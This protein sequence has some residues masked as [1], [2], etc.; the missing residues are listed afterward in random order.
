MESYKEQRIVKKLTNLVVSLSETPL[1]ERRYFI[2]LD[3]ALK[4]GRKLRGLGID[5]T[6]LTPGQRKICSRIFELCNE[7]EEEGIDVETLPDRHP[8]LNQAITRL[9]APPCH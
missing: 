6:Q 8:E 5:F 4:K 2:D 1:H 9:S 7:L 3:E